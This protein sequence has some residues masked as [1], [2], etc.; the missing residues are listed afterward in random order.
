MSFAKSLALPLAAL[1]LL[2]ACGKADEDKKAAQANQQVSAEGR[3]EEGKITFKG[4]GLDMSFVLPKAMR[5]EAKADK[6][7]RILYPGSTIGGVAVVGSQANGGQG[8]DSE[9]ELSFAT[10]D[11]PER[12]A[13]WYRDPARAK[14][15]HVTAA[16]REGADLVISGSQSDGHRVKVRLAARTGGG[17]QGRVTIHHN[18]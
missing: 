5:G 15:F 3:A 14:D 6:N 8:G 13:A 1:S 17:T 18:D 7:S 2:S 12:V 16:A 11:P 4:P 9:V 10:S